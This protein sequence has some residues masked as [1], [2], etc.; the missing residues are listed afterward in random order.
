MPAHAY[1]I[2]IFSISMLY[3]INLSAGTTDQMIARG[4]HRIEIQNYGRYGRG[5][6]EVSVDILQSDYYN[7]HHE[8]NVI[9]FEDLNKTINRE[10]DEDARREYDQWFNEKFNQKMS[11]Y[12]QAAEYYEQIDGQAAE[13]EQ[14]EEQEP[15]AEDEQ[16]EQETGDFSQ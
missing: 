16:Q 8:S 9:R 2:A 6:P 13:E 3:Y 4:E 7:L 1:R 12:Q 11:E 15:A 10:I 5:T 14:L